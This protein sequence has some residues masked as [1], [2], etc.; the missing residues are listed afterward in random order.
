[1]HQNRLVVEQ[2]AQIELVIFFHGVT[3]IYDMRTETD[4]HFGKALNMLSWKRAGEKKEKNRKSN[5]VWKLKLFLCKKFWYPEKLWFISEQFFLF[6]CLFVFF[7]KQETKVYCGGATFRTFW[8]PSELKMSLGAQNHK[9]AVFTNLL[10]VN[11]EALGT[12]G[13]CC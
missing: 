10:R 6:V 7:F 8:L 12:L 4:Q 11:K 13:A 3:S 9:Y 1:M 5:I 2:M